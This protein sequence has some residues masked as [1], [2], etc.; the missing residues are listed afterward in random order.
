MELSVRDVRFAEHEVDS[1]SAS[2]GLYNIHKHV[3][4]GFAQGLAC[5]VGGMRVFRKFWLGAGTY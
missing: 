1:V 5:S 4:Q 3:V 2:V